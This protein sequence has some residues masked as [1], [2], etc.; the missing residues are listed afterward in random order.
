M[1]LFRTRFFVFYVGFLLKEVL[2][3]KHIWYIYYETKNESR[4]SEK[5]NFRLQVFP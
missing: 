2:N 1:I 5:N 3:L 4:L